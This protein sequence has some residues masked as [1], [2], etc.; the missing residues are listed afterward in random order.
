MP[1]AVTISVQLHDAD[2]LVCV[3]YPTCY[4]PFVVVRLAEGIDLLLR[5][6]ATVEA[7]AAVVD[8]ARQ[9]LLAID[10][11]PVG[12]VSSIGLVS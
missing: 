11:G 2:G 5:D 9:A 12:A 6:V 7:L 4:A 3:P 10:T 8:D 1:P